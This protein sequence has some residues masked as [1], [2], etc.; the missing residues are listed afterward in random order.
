MSNEHLEKCA[1][2]ING[3]SC[4]IVSSEMDETQLVTELECYYIFKAYLAL[5]LN[6]PSIRDNDA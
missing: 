5:N 6:T 1:H 2:Q 3:S 4:S